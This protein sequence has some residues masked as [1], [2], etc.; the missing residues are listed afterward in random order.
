MDELEF[1]QV[2]LGNSPVFLSSPHPFL[3]FHYIRPCDDVNRY[4][5][6]APTLSDRG[7]IFVPDTTSKY[8]LFKDYS[9]IQWF[10]FNQKQSVVAKIPVHSIF[11]SKSLAHHSPAYSIYPAILVVCPFLFY[12]LSSNSHYLIGPMVFCSRASHLNVQTF[13]SNCII[14]LILVF[15]ILSFL[16]I[17]ANLIIIIIRGRRRRIW[18]AMEM[19]SAQLGI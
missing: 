2:L 14:S 19:R 10:S 18:K 8:Y 16:D 7:F 4:A 17:L 11:F 6:I 3:S 15:G 5:Y 9:T 12:P 1:G 13:L